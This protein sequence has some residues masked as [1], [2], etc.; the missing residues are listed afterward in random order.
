MSIML[1]AVALAG[2]VVG[3][4]AAHGSLIQPMP[5]N[6]VD[7]EL[8]AYKGGRF[9]N[10]SCPHPGNMPPVGLPRNQ[11]GPVNS[12]GRGSCW[13]CN[14]VNGT[15]PCKAAQTCVWFTEGT[16]IGCA[17]PGGDSPSPTPHCNTTM[18]ATNNDPY[19]RTMAIKVK[20]LSPEDRYRWNPWRAPGVAPIYDP[21]GMAGGAP[22][23]RSTQL[24]YYNTRFAKQG[25]LGSKVLPPN[26]TGVMW[27]AGSTVETKW[28]VVGQ[29]HT[30][31][32]PHTRP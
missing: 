17:E 6:A 23:W 28:C 22:E 20:A 2:V 18:N 12:H 26:P 1:R 11:W 7:R 3:H 9:G 24:S 14:C 8:P 25:D 31:H 19:F 10:H 13:G 27:R 32:I 21:C 30:L 16:S 4:V 15:A 29:S 5:R